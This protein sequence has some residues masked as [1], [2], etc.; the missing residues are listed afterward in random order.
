[1]NR[2]IL[3]FIF[4]SFFITK[5][6]AQENSLP[7]AKLTAAAE[8]GYNYTYENYGAVQAYLKFPLKTYFSADCGIKAVTANIYALTAVLRTTFPTKRDGEW[9]LE[10]I[11]LYRA[12]VRNQLSDFSA[13]LRGGYLRN[14]FEADFGFY[15]RFIGDLKP[16]EMLTQKRYIVEMFNLMYNVEGRLKKD[17]AR[18]NIGLRISNYDDFQIERAMSPIFA[19]KARFSPN[20]ENQKFYLWAEIALKPAGAL[21]L[22]SNFYDFSSRV[23]IC[24]S[25]PMKNIS[26]TKSQK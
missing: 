26:T 20:K 1:M 19:L 2:K 4:L 8:Y 9:Q 13:G 15:V 14:H 21:H 16:D 23:G 18:W 17:D 25:F 6:A 12:V 5:I 3:L 7:Y 10:N 22:A 24:Y 11:Y